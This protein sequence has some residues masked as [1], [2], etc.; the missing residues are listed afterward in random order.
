MSRSPG[1]ARQR[2]AGGLRPALLSG[3]VFPGLG[4]L[5]NRAY[6]RALVLGGASVA[7]L[8][9]LLRRVVVEANARIPS[10]PDQAAAALLDDPLWPLHLAAE[11]QRANATFF[12]WI[13]VAIMAVWALAIWDAWRD[14]GRQAPP[15]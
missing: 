12:L 5:A 1:P 7:L 3:L 6:G 15:P 10:D 14:A 8:V 4:Q 13:T 11:I 2:P 9:V